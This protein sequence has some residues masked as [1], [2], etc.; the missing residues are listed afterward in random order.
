VGGTIGDW[1]LVAVEPWT[2]LSVRPGYGA[3]RKVSFL[4]QDI[5]AI[6]RYDLRIL[7]DSCQ[8]II[9]DR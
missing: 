2:Q 1:E 4:H 7:P 9:N 8:L 6:L 3:S 5:A